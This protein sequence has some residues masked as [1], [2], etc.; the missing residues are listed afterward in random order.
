M[1]RICGK[2]VCPAGCPSY[3][4]RSAELG[5]MIGEC[6]RCGVRLCEYDFI[7]YSYG[8]PYCYD[9]YRY[10]K[11]RGTRKGEHDGG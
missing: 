1:C 5:E 10:V 6:G 11:K 4:G 2:Y 9:C 7:V 8:K 3:E